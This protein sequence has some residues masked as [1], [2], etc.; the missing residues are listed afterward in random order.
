MALNVNVFARRGPQV[1]ERRGLDRVDSRW[2]NF[3]MTEAVRELLEKAM[4]LG[5][6]DRLLLANVLTEVVLTQSSDAPSVPDWHWPIL[7]A[8]L[9]D[10]ED[11]PDDWVSWEELRAELL[12]DASDAA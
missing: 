3:G 10:M 1:L 5:E 11:N 9:K 2:Y 8:R 4:A 6:K 7:E 12:G